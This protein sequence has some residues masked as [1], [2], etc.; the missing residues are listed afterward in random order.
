MENKIEVKKHEPEVYRVYDYVKNKHL[1]QKNGILKSYLANNLHITERALRKITSEINTSDELPRIISTTGSCYMCDTKEEC[2]K[3]IRNTYNVAIA[4]FKKAKK[5][6][7][8]VGLNG[9]IKLKLGPYY[10]EVIETF[11]EEE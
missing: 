7:K 5:M 3:S 6:E 1:G 10:K 2:E 4:L 9:Q 8:K 11:S